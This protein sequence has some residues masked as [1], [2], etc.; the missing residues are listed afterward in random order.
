LRL[1]LVLKFSSP[2]AAAAEFTAWGFNFP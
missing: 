2:S 1:S